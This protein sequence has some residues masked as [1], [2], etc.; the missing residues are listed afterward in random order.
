MYYK[1]S[2]YAIWDES[3]KKLLPNKINKILPTYFAYAN[4]PILPLPSLK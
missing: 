1:R 4:Q 3:V 2:A